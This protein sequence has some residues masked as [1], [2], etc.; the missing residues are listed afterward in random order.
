MTAGGWIAAGA[1]L[2]LLVGL[3]LIAGGRGM[4]GVAAW[5]R[6]DGGAR[7]CDADFATGYG[8]TGRMDR[9]I[10]KAAIGSSPEEWKSARQ[11][12]PWHRAQMGCYFLLI[13]ES[14]G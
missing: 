12:R 9:L 8:L 14:C 6:Q 13:E 10:R 11:L 4:R 2:A 1:V 3:V 7:Q 5:G